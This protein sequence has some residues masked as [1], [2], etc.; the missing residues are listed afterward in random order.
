[1]VRPYPYQKGTHVATA[2]IERKKMLLPVGVSTTRSCLGIEVSRGHSTH[3]KRG[4][5]NGI[6]LT[7]GE[8]LNLMRFKIRMSTRDSLCSTT[9]E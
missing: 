1:M 5:I 7:S 2:V 8:G 3:G 4:V 9:G 6:G